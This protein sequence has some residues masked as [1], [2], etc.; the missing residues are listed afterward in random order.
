MKSQEKDTLY[1][2]LNSNESTDVYYQPDEVGFLEGVFVDGRLVAV[3]SDMGY[4]SIWQDEF[5]N[6]PQLRMG[7][8][9]VVFALTQEGSIAQQQIDFY[10][11]LTE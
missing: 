8:N 9:L 10:T 4:G 2:Y 5:E 1:F 6:E 11:E 3:Y 7:V